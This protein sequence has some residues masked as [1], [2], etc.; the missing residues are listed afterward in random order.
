M[1]AQQVAADAEEVA[2]ACDFA[3]SGKA[4]AE[5][6]DVALLHQVVGQR[7]V[8]GGP[9]QVGPQGLRGPLVECRELIAVHG[10]LRHAGRRGNG[11]A[12]NGVFPVHPA[13]PRLLAVLRLFH[14]RLDRSWGGAGRF[15][16]RPSRS[17]MRQETMAEMINPRPS[18]S[19]TMPMMKSG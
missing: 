16:S 13:V 3:V 7:R 5:K 10:R 4:R 11:D 9:R 18:I 19:V 2:A 1:V 12:W 14:C 17:L 15:G 6:A 8:A